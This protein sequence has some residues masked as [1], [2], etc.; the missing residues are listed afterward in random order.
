MCREISACDRGGTVAVERGVAKKGRSSEGT[1]LASKV[2]E[3]R[4]LAGLCGAEECAL[5]ESARGGR[6]AG[7]CREDFRPGNDCE[8]GRTITVVDAKVVEEARLGIESGGGLRERM[9]YKGGLRRL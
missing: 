4:R 3:R 2:E 9:G 8:L 5:G 7:L 1:H 6:R